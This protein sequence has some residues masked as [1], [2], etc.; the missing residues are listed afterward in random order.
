MYITT[1]EGWLYLA[2]IT[3]LASQRMVG[4]SMSDR[5]KADLVCQALSTAYWRR[6]LDK[7][8]IVQ[9]ESASIRNARSSA[10]GYHELDRRLLQ[11]GPPAFVDRLSSAE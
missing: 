7:G 3:D 11:S 9:S 6:K 8:L 5:I 1:G 4:W 2:V 10:I